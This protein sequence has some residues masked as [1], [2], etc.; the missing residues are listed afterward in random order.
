M[1]L[2]KLQN[3]H[4][5]AIVKLHSYSNDANNTIFLTKVTDFSRNKFKIQNIFTMFK[6]M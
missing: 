6:N 2:K 3:L 5:K 4:Q 1:I